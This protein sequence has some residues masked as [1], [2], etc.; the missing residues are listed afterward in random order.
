[1]Y[2]GNQLQCRD[3]L[4]QIMG[5]QSAGELLHQGNPREWRELPGA[6]MRMAADAWLGPGAVAD[7]PTCTKAALRHCE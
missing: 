2:I 3:V 1:M 5:L 4:Q 6:L 7:T